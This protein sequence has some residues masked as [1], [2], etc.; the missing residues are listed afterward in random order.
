MPR[1]SALGMVIAGFVF[2]V[3]F[4]IVWHIWWLAALSV[5]AALATIFIR[6]FDE[7]T[8]YVIPAAEVARLEA[9]TI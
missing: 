9:S 8:E 2:L 3:G 1:N 6:A 7:N 4:G 5:L